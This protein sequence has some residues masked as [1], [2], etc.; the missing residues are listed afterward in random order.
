[1]QALAISSI[2]FIYCFRIFLSDSPT[3]P[4]MTTLLVVAN[5]SHATLASGSS[6]IKASRTA[7]DILSHTLSGCPSD[8]DSEVKVKLLLLNFFSKYFQLVSITKRTR[9][10]ICLYKNATNRLTKIRDR[11]IK[12]PYSP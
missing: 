12:F 9:V 11:N 2:R 1:M 8:T 3:S 7:S 5:V 10:I 4:P 6:E